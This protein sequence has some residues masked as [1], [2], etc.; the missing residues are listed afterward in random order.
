MFNG[1]VAV[2]TDIRVRLTRYAL[3]TWRSNPVYTFFGTGLGSAGTVL[4]QHYPELGS[5]KEIVQNE[6]ASLLLETGVM[7]YFMLAISGIT[8]IQ[9]LR[10]KRLGT[11]LSLPHIYWFALVLAYAITICFFSGLPNAL[12]IYLLIPL[13]LSFIYY[14]NHQKVLQ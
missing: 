1:Y 4:Y 5:P 8:L 11:S 3:E 6:Y 9:I 10:Q 13:I 14:T 12:H 7:G 2:S